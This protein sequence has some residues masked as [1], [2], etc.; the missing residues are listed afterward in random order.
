[1]YKVMRINE[2]GQV[3][4]SKGL[5]QFHNEKED[6][7]FRDFPTL[8]EAKQYCRDFVETYPQVICTIHEGD[9][10]SDPI[11]SIQDEQYWEL[12]YKNAEE[13]RETNKSGE[14]LAK[15]MVLI[16]LVLVSVIFGIVSHFLGVYDIPLWL[17]LIILP[18]LTVVTCKLF[19]W[20]FP[21][22]C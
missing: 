16:A 19:Y 4:S 2:Y 11:D 7:L 18:V 9:L 22:I 15:N 3:Y 10:A 8:E 13:W 21:R 1:M 14:K 20:L 17:K 5:L 12:H 6:T